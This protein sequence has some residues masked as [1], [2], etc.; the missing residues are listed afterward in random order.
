MLF[1]EVKSCRAK[2]TKL[3][4]CG[5][6]RVLVCQGCWETVHQYHQLACGIIQDRI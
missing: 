3:V 2:T 5:L 6:C 4:H 1:C